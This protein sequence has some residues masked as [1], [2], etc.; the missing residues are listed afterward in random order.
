VTRGTFRPDLYYRLNVFP[1]HVPPLADRRE[2]IPLLVE[3][4]VAQFNRRMGKLIRS[5]HADSLT[6]LCHR[7][8]PGNIRESRHVIERAMILCP[9]PALVVEPADLLSGRDRPA[10]RPAQATPTGPETL[11]TLDAIA[12][13]P[14]PGVQNETRSHVASRVMFP[15]AGTARRSRPC[16]SRFGVKCRLLGRAPPA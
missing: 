14:I 8:W 15:S 4:F 16:A 11:A 3:S 13:D 2:D 10:A 1:I 5:V 12:R 7:D 6:H 9:S